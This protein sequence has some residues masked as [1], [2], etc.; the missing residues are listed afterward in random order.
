MLSW[1]KFV[2]VTQEPLVS[3]SG[4]RA[5]KKAYMFA[6]FFTELY[7]AYL[8]QAYFITLYGD[9]PISVILNV[10]RILALVFL[11]LLRQAFQCIHPAAISVLFI[12]QSLFRVVV[13]FLK[14]MEI[15]YSIFI[16][17]IRNKEIIYPLMI[18]YFKIK[19]SIAFFC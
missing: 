1:L 8:R 11:F 2:F 14:N 12:Q 5:V 4:N 3:P 19:I 15:I 6:D 18:L 13:L 9:R 7:P 17:A 10:K 16:I